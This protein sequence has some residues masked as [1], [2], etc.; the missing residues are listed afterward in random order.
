[1]QYISHS[2]GKGKS[3]YSI[4]GNLWYTLK[5]LW[6]W[7][8]SAVLI[9]LLVFIPS[10][11]GSYA[12]T[13]L[14]SVVVQDLEEGVGLAV[15]V[16]HI[17]GICLVRWI[18]NTCDY[19]AN[20]WFERSMPSFLQFFRKKF[21]AKIMD[22]DYDRLEDGP[23]R[24]TIGNVA[25]ALRYGRGLYGM[26]DLL[27]GGSSCLILLTFYGILIARVGLWLLLVVMISVALNYVLLSVARKMYS[28]YY[29]ENSRYASRTAYL[30]TQAGD[31][32][33][34]KDIR[35]YRLQK[36]FLKKYEESLKEMDRLFGKIHF[37]YQVRGIFSSLLMFARNGIIYGALLYLLTGGEISA[38]GLVYYISLLSSF[39]GFFNWLVYMIL[40]YNS[41]NM[42]MSYVRDFLSWENAW[43]RPENPARTEA[44]KK[45]PAKLEL[46]HVSFSYPG[47]E[48]QVLKDVNL[49]LEPGEKLALLG[50]NGA[51]KTTLVKLICGFYEPT[52]GEILL[53]DIP[54]REYQ[55]EEYYSLLSVL[56]QDYTMLPL[57]LDENLT[58]CGEEERNPEK[59]ERSLRLSG[60]EERYHRLP[61]KGKTP[62]LSGVQ[63]GGVDFSGGEYQKL[64]FARALYQES[65]LIILDEPT[66][67]LDP[68]AENELYQNFSEAMENATAVYIS[69]RLASTQFCD[70]IVLLENGRIVEEGT[71]EELMRA[72]GSYA[73][74]YEMQ[75]R[76][77]A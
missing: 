11:A 74:L 39:A 34:G 14:P 72:G 22:L 29:G 63:A 73:K 30:S 70:R 15:L 36:L 59:L 27:I 17:V 38:S 56:F 67:A 24:E 4:F 8:K 9:I 57:S 49:V 35:I 53:N 44:M 48:T 47:S 32:A 25:A 23:S 28:V 33:A 12:Q 61:R 62:M 26:P 75:S 77:Y 20:L 52:G 31:A 2:Y 3:H 71:H 41:A 16:I 69:H 37:W 45:R 55:R 65:P 64:L 5:S 21:T 66:A 68:I 18:G 54:V 7:K 13:L 60:F 6:E 51:G 46:R 50:L 58:G 10:V 43:V 40:S 19:A 42:S 1:M 76:Y